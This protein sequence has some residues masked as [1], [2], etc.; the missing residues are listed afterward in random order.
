MESLEA[1]STHKLL[2]AWTQAK[3]NPIINVD[4]KNWSKIA[5]TKEAKTIPVVQ[6]MISVYRPRLSDKIPAG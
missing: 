3:E 6:K 4:I 5:T 1:R 2:K